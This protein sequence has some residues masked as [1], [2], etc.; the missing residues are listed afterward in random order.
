MI[1][2]TW[3]K[4]SRVL[5]VP[6][7]LHLRR[8]HYHYY[9]HMVCA[10]HWFHVHIFTCIIRVVSIC[11]LKNVHIDTVC[12]SSPGLLSPADGCSCAGFLFYVFL[13]M[14]LQN[15]FLPLTCE[16]RCCCPLFCLSV[17]GGHD[18]NWSSAA[19]TTPF[20][21]GTDWANLCWLKESTME[22]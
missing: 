21:T 17:L 11:A 5:F 22:S 4:C 14:H 12:Y 7:G 10:T 8:L 18:C 20:F 9:A 1:H 3:Y 19:D 2:K 13:L 15:L 16:A 6:E